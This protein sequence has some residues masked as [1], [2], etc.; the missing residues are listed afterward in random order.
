MTKKRDMPEWLWAT[1][2]IAFVV[3]CLLFAAGI[4]CMPGCAALDD[5]L[6][7]SPAGGS[8]LVD[9][10]AGRASASVGVAD[11]SAAA[12]SAGVSQEV[13]TA[14]SLLGLFG[15]WGAGAGWALTAGAGLYAHLRGRRYGS[16]LTAVIR[17]VEAATTKGDKVRASV[18]AVATTLGVERHLHGIV[19]KINGV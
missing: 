12:P 5:I 2:L 10:S 15:P 16:A 3:F 14:A 18:Q 19:K 1:S 4:T 13:R 7:D 9:A 11:G 8:G 17:G 6:L